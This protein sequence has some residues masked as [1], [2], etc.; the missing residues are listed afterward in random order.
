MTTVVTSPYRA[1]HICRNRAFA[2]L[3]D[4]SEPG[5]FGN[6]PRPSRVMYAFAVIF[7]IFPTPQFSVTR[8]TGTTSRALEHIH[9][10]TYIPLG[11]SCP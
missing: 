6:S 4:R 11:I 2:V 8:D 1:I 10:Q 5:Y 9:K 3:L 7:R